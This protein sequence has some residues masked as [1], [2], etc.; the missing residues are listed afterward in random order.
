M[1]N[2]DVQKMYLYMF[3]TLI[4]FIELLFILFLSKEK[5]DTFIVLFCLLA[6]INLIIGLEM[7]NPKRIS[8]S[9]FAFGASLIAIPLLSYNLWLL[10][11]VF[12]IIVITIIFRHENT[13][14]PITTFDKNVVDYSFDG[15]INW[16]YMYAFFG[17]IALLKLW[18]VYVKISK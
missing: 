14:C 1:L 15:R 13:G 4:I 17:L 16:D 3:V 7:E 2:K 6:Q 18:H 8:L 12:L 9:H 11:I 10:S 5:I